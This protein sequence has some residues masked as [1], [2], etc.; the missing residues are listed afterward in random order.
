MDNKKKKKMKSTYE[1]W[2]KYQFLEYIE[3]LNMISSFL[4]ISDQSNCQRK[5]KSAYLI[6]L[7][8]IMKT[9]FNCR[10]KLQVFTLHK[11]KKK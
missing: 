3:A 6:S 2:I 10:L 5:Y 1:I 4:V 7:R 9:E 11:V 8:N